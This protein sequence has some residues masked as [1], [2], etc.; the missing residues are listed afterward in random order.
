MPSRDWVMNLGNIRRRRVPARA[1]GGGLGVR[2]ALA[3]INTRNTDLVSSDA[4]DPSA[5]WNLDARYQ[6]PPSLT[7]ES[8]LF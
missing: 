7:A 1:V 6:R 3:K 5:C 2:L 4:I 8:W